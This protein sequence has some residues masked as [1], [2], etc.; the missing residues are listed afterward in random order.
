MLGNVATTNFGLEED[1]DQK[2]KRERESNL[3]F[4]AQS[5]SMDIYQTER[6]SITSRENRAGERETETERQTQRDRDRQTERDRKIERQRETDRQTDR[7][8]MRQKNKLYLISRVTNTSR[9]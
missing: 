8:T 1:L 7:Q 4:Y 5:T 2:E 6:G 9:N 3:V